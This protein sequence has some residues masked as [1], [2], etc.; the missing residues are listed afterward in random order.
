MQD[1]VIVGGILL[2][3]ATKGTIALYETLG[4]QFATSHFAG[5]TAQ[6]RWR[7][8]AVG[9]CMHICVPTHTNN[10]N[11]NTT[12][13]RLPLCLLRLDGRHRPPLHE[14]ALPPLQRR[15]GAFIHT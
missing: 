6:V 14:A 11:T 12:G 9:R 8:A 4:I 5:M 15:A 10:T 3:I 13:R 2:N 1:I 7:L